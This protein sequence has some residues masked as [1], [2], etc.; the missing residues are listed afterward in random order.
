MAFED[1]FTLWN[2]ADPD[3]AMRKSARSEYALLM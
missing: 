1:L 2:G 3:L